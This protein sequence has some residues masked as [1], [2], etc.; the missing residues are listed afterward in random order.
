MGSH[1]R[2][3][4]TLLINDSTIRK[5][6]VQQGIKYVHTLRVN[7]RTGL[8]IAAFVLML[9]F[10]PV[11]LVLI[12][13][14]MVLLNLAIFMG[15]D[16]IRPGIPKKIAKGAFF[17]LFLFALGIGLKI[18]V[19]EIYRVPSN[20][21]EN[22][23]YTRDVILVNKLAYGPILPRSP[24]EIPWVNLLFYPSRGTGTIGNEKRWPDK[25]LSGT[26]LIRRGDIL[27]YQQAYGFHIVKRCVAL[28]GDALKIDG[29]KVY[30][31]GEDLPYA[32]TI[33]EDYLLSVT[34]RKACYKILDSLGISGPF[35]PVQNGSNTIRGALSREELVL[36]KRLGT[37]EVKEKVMAPYPPEKALFADPQGQQWTLDAMGPFA[38]PK[39]GMKIEINQ[40][41][42]EVY[43]KTIQDFEDR[44]LQKKEDGYYDVL[45]KRVVSHTFSQNFCF[46]MGDNRKHSIDSRYFGFVP[47][48]NVVGKVPYVLLSNGDSGLFLKE[49]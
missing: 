6:G 11:W 27:V 18:F 4:P 7:L 40:W 12:A 46:L 13:G 22:S 35:Y 14:A 25:R 3:I 48:S 42:F 44:V 20:S 38:V 16:R 32:H 49:L 31:N 36:L 9:I 5:L 30:V 28:A 17:V 43:G 19:F 33:K 10:A 2:A 8:L 45:G 23:I 47:E 39:K 41:S 37:P 21:M 26:D 15:L 29:G 24:L 34:D 1:L